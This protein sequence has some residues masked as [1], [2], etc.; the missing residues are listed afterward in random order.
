MPTY[1]IYG[2]LA[3][4]VPMLFVFAFGACVGS[5]INVI[6]YRLPLGIG[7]VSPPSKCPSCQTQ[8][9]FRENIPVFGWLMLKGRCRFCQTRISAEY[10]TVEAI[11]GLLFVG[12][13]WML[14]VVDPRTEWF[15]FPIGQIRPEWADA[16][17]RDVWPAIIM[18]H[19]LL[20]SL[21]A[22]TIVDFKTFT[23]PL[24]LT[25]FAAIVGI[26]THVGHAAVE[27][28]LSSGLQQW[29][30]WVIPIP[31]GWGVVLMTFGGMLGLAIAVWLVHAGLLRQ[32][33]EDYDEWEQEVLAKRAS[34]S[35]G[36][37][38]NEPEAAAEHE[39]RERQVPEAG[40]EGDPEL[41]M[42]YPHA[43]REV[44]R[45]LLFLA[46]CLGLAYVGAM[47]AGW[48]G[49]TGEPPFWVRALS[50]ALLGYLVGGGVVWGVRIFGSLAF[51]REAMGLGD[52]HVL[53]AVGACLGWVDAT[54]TFFAAVLVGLIWAIGASLASVARKGGVVRMMAFGPSLAIGT[55]VVVVGKPWIEMGLGILF[56]RPG[57]IDLP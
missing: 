40:L 44:L 16:W 42:E 23:I 43:R 48:F 24:V 41:W 30:R 33:F 38:S 51:G 34:E 22:M 5:L 45:E 54:L 21:V 47:A 2:L 27:G 3:A 55:V 10:P 57:G 25:W 8:L 7:I 53:G 28:P 56:R 17:F 35:E 19:L 12:C 18:W 1:Q 11:T 49:W 6:A 32:S 52:V 26:L 46:P 29:G 39:D 15:G 50:G 31:D 36:E 4:G 9:T 20:G 14:A 13:Y 37:S